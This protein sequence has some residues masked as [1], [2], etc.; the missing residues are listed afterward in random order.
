MQRMPSPLC[1]ALAITTLATPLFA[2]ER[3]QFI[4]QTVP[5][6][7]E[8]G[9]SYD[10]SVIY[11]NTGDTP[12]LA[13]D[14]YVLRAIST[15]SQAVWG[16]DHVTLSSSDRIPPGESQ[17]FSFTIKAPQEPGPYPF[18]W[19]LQKAAALLGDPTPPLTLN[20]SS[21]AESHATFV[22]QMLPEQLEAG[23]T[24][25]ATFQYQNTGEEAWNAQSGIHLKAV[26]VPAGTWS[27]D[28]IPLQ[29]NEP[30]PP[31]GIATFSIRFT[32][33]ARAGEHPFQWQLTR[34]GGEIF[35]DPTPR[36]L[37]QV[38]NASSARPAEFVFQQVP[39]KMQV[40]ASY[41]VSLT[42]K[43]TGGQAWRSGEVFLAPQNPPNNLNWVVDRVD[44]A[45]GEDVAPGAMKTFTFTV[46][47]T[48]NPAIHPFQW[49]LSHEKQGWFGEV[50]EQIDVHVYQR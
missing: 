27:H 43:N 48:Q 36:T 11:K 2:A 6:Q 30:V 25:R 46:K 8:S 34:S 42:F 10:V 38:G 35:G 29:L 21:E 40:G 44:L 41:T 15:E 7:L 5:S 13:T 1:F 24:Y 17:V 4:S 20:V 16:I 22:S 31:K 28:D 50:S 3:A 23:G 37:L 9:K 19:S 45:A 26:N 47:A 18:Q 49:Q 39:E 33:P 12:W 14:G 32:A